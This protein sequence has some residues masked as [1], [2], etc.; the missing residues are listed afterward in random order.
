M[1]TTELTEN[2]PNDQ[3]PPQSGPAHPE[4]LFNTGAINIAVDAAIAD[5]GATG[6]FMVPGTP[7][8]DVRPATTPLII[9]LPDGQTIKSTHT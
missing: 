3:P 2:G 1:T 6:H 8:L 5:A 4:T 9:H 7:V